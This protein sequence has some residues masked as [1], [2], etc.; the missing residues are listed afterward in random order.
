MVRPSVGPYLRKVAVLLPESQSAKLQRGP[1]PSNS[2]G[3]ADDLFG[4]Q[5]PETWGPAIASYSKSVRMTL[6]AVTKA[7]LG[8]QAINVSSTPI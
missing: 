3:A 2:R 8:F 5:K 4:T 6:S 1:R 7:R